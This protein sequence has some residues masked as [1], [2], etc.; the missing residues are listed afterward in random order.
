MLIYFIIVKGELCREKK[1]HFHTDAAQA[2]GKIPM[3]VEQLKIDLMS[4][5]G[6]KIYGPKGVGALYIRR[7]PRVRIEAQMSGGG[8]ERGLRSGT[9]PT[10]LIVGFG[11]ACEISNKER[12][13]DYRHISR[14]AERLI[15]GINQRLPNVIRN[16]DLEM[17]YPG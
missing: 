15:Q 4:I 7:R 6:H 10:P 13:M 2:V 5:S 12:E 3:N 9:L 8:Q 17:W 16:G 11:K 1:V 14:L